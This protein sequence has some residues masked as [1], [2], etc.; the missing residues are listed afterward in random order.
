[1][2]GKRCD[3][4]AGQGWVIALLDDGQLRIDACWDCNRNGKIDRVKAMENV[5]TM[6]DLWPQLLDALTT[7]QKAFEVADMCMVE[8]EVGE[9]RICAE[10]AGVLR[11]LL[12]KMREL[13]D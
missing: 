12:K 11:D 7:A 4:C 3:L 13:V 2:S 10:Q 1:M 6:I 8:P 5:N 9:L